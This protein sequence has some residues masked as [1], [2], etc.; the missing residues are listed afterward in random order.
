MSNFN[1]KGSHSGQYGVANI[2]RGK[3]EEA[4]SH[5]NFNQHGGHG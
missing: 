2:G 4:Y 1:Q 5:L 3:G